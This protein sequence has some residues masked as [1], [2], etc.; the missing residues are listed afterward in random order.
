MSPF[1]HF[2][3]AGRAD[4][5]IDLCRHEAFVSQQ[6][7]HTADIGTAIE[8][9]SG[10]AVS[11]SVWRR[12]RVESR[13]LDMFLEHPTYTASRQAFGKPVGKGRLSRA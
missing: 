5:R 12:A 9:M 3:Q 11:Q 8:Q 1:V 13:R 10:K 7:L 2:A 4:V 6:F